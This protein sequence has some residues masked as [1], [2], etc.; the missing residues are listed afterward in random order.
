MLYSTAVRCS[1]DHNELEDSCKLEES[2]YQVARR[3]MQR[4]D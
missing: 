4:K 3:T 2:G 1:R